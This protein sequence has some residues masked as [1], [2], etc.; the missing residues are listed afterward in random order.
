MERFYGGNMHV[1][2]NYNP[3]FLKDLLF[4]IHIV[5]RILNEE[6]IPLKIKN[7]DLLIFY[8][9]EK[10]KNLY[11]K[12]KLQ[13]KLKPKLMDSTIYA[14]EKNFLSIFEETSSLTEILSLRNL[15]ME[16][17]SSMK[18]KLSDESDKNQKQAREFF[19]Q[20]TLDN[21]LDLLSDLNLNLLKKEEKPFKLQMIIEIE[22][23]DIL[24]Q[25]NE[26][27]KSLKKLHNYVTV[28]SQALDEK[29]DLRDKILNHIKENFVQE[30][31]TQQR[32]VQNIAIDQE[33]LVASPTS[34]MAK[35]R[36]N[37]VYNWNQN[38][39]LDRF[40]GKN[41]TKV[42]KKMLLQLTIESPKI[43]YNVTNFIT[44]EIELE[45]TK[46][47]GIDMHKLNT[48]YRKFLD[49][50]KGIALKVTSNSSK[51]HREGFEDWL[52]KI[53][54]ELNLDVFQMTLCKPFVER[55]SKLLIL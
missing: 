39:S 1:N 45:A 27:L 47:V 6:K 3:G 18:H 42:Q 38:I 26:M 22:R 36:K 29:K 43:T 48:E 53:N 13:S 55:I 16:T 30:I 15:A 33:S 52:V 41:S 9:A 32:F 46:V 2:Y 51:I 50:P 44:T 5:K 12:S 40:F 14:K 23:L 8:K 49:I 20:Y 11:M 24:I 10:Y 4:F 37:S 17:L 19:D 31:S 28:F 54:V 7:K 34:L 25:E 35:S 21:P